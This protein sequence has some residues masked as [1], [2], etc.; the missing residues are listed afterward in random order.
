[1][2][3]LIDL[4]I[5]AFNDVLK[6]DEPAPGGGSAS[7]LSSAYGVGLALMVIELTVKKAKFSDYKEAL[8]ALHT[9]LSSCNAQ[10]MALID[11]D[12]EAFNV[13]SAVF[14]MPKETVEDK[15]KRS[16]ALQAGLQGAS[17]VPYEVLALSHQ[18]LTLVAKILSHFNQTSASDLG[19]AALMLN[20]GAKGAYLNVLINL[21]D[22]K[23]EDFVTRY[24]QDAE[25][26]VHESSELAD[27]I[28]QQIKS[29]ITE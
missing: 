4:D 8:T 12:T 28:Y 7:A 29:I 10:L 27:R 25:K 13:V 22:I 14:K 23:D 17:K 5:K 26:H 24:R 18:A 16:E 19:V 9:D 2:K 11:K 1:M 15:K 21:A 6:S 3:A 20:T